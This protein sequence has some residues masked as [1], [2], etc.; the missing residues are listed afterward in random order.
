MSFRMRLASLPAD[1]AALEVL[2]FMAHCHDRRGRVTRSFDPVRGPVL[3][4]EVE[5]G[6]LFAYLFRR[7]GYPNAGWDFNRLARY[8][9][10]T[11]RDDLFLIVEPTIAGLTSQVFSFMGPASVHSAAE[12]YRRARVT[13][14]SE[15]GNAFWVRDQELR[16]WDARDPL[17]PYAQ[18]AARALDDLLK[19]VWLDEE[20]AIDIFGGVPR[21]SRSVRPANLGSPQVRGAASRHSGAS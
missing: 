11:P 14:Q 20:G 8:S 17:T 4:A 3:G 7:F 18:A 16:R 9:L 13:A 5:Y 6:A 12:A 1:V 2:Q 15:G 19:P 21:T 10:A